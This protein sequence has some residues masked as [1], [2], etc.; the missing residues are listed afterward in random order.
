MPSAPAQIQSAAQRMVSLA[1]GRVDHIP[2]F[3][4]AIGLAIPMAVLLLT[5]RVDW[6]MYVGFGAFTGIYSKYEP[7]RLRFR[8]QSLAG[9]MLTI[10]VTLGAA[11][12]Q[13]GE[14]MSPLA[15]SWL[16]LLVGAVIAGFSATF[17][18]A[19][20]LTPG[21]AIFPLF[22]V[23]AVAAAP[24]AAPVWVAFLIAGSC[25]SLCVGLGL[26]GHWA[27]ER[28]PGAEA[29]PARETW[30]RAQ[31]G[32]EFSRFALAAAIA[33][34]LGL[35]SGL[36]FPYWAQI[37]AIAPLAAPGRALQIERGLH[38]VI[39]TTLGVVTTAFL[40]SFPAEPWQLVV[41]VV[42]LQF[43]AELYVMRNYA[44]AL[45]F[46]TP[47][48]LLMVQLAHPQPV[49]PT[50]EARVVETAIGVVVGTA[51]VV[52]AALW[53]RRSTRRAAGVEG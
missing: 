46:I 7:T 26:L 29:R 9:A 16:A 41:W 21:G 45:L 32:A 36:P 35:A 5:D 14:S 18:L 33:G 8:R 30:T 15:E 20:G 19:R 6:A 48:A 53:D 31:L 50:L 40:L 17:V 34:V 2:A 24:P 23:A 44:F 28:H 42:V 12:A 25:A 11:L 49:G 39:G 52:T 51:M 27:G 3:R 37:A 43:I 10:C 4:I 13:L 47:L 1:P 22:A 38:R